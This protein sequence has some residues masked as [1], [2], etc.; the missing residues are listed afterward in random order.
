MSRKLI[1][2]PEDVVVEELEGLVASV[3]HLAYLDGFPQVGFVHTDTLRSAR[4]SLPFRKTS[5]VTFVEVA[6]LTFMYCFWRTRSVG[7]NVYRRSNVWAAG[8]ALSRAMD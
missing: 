5:L 6:E 1:N 3:P 8:F 7:S 4:S 2:K